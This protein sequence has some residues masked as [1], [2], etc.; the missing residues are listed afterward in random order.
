MKK[1]KI[2]R[3]IIKE[4]IDLHVHVGPEVFPR[5]YTA[6]SLVDSETGKL[7]GA[8]LKSHFFATTPFIKE[9][10]NVPKNF[11][12]IGSVSLNHAVGGLNPEA[13]RAAASLSH[14]PIVVWFP[15]ISAQ[16]FLDK[17]EYE[18][19][20]EWA[21]GTNYRPRKSA[22]VRG[23][24][25]T[26]GNQLTAE[27]LEIV[28]TIKEVGAVLATGHVSSEESRLL[29]VEASRIGLRS[30]MVTH[31][32][33]QLIEMPVTTQKEL[34]GIGAFVEVCYSMYLIDEIPVRKIADQIKSVGPEF[35]ILSSDVGQVRSPSPSRA[36]LD[37]MRRLE[38][39]GITEVDFYRML[40]TNPRKLVGH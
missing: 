1:E 40:V 10:K 23:I 34:A 37:F 36:L 28:R 12:L 8:C 13:V 16:N 25:V 21:K 24:R 6:G 14:G 9:L 38:V 26:D 4:A 27:A 17:S 20:P 18:V 2:Y 35:C 19:R 31:P 5:K 7:G 32:I 39:E 29:I 33:Y 3:E 15:T 11:R 22:D 30:M